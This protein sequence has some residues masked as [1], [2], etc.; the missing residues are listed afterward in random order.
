MK[1][2][3][4]TSLL[5]I[6]LNSLIGFAGDVGQVSIDWWFLFSITAI[7]CTG[8]FLGSAIGRKI[9]GEKLKRGFGWFILILGVFILLKETVLQ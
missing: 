2:A 5:I 9:A 4:G 8:I 1:K 7:A 6:A 3:I